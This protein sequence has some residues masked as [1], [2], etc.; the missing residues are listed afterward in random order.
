MKNFYNIKVLLLV[1]LLVVVGLLT[2]CSDDEDDANTG[3]VEL[4]SFGPTGAKHGQTIKIVGR[5]L[6]QVESVQMA[7]AT[8]NKSQFTSQS[9]EM[10]ELVIPASAER[11]RITLKTV[12]GQDIV[13]K[14]VLSFEVLVEISSVTESAK[15]G[16]NI[17]V[18]GNNLNWVDSVRFGSLPT[19]VKTFVSKSMTELVL[20]VPLEAKTGTM[21]FYTG[22]TEPLVIETEE[23]LTLTVPSISGFSPNPVERGSNLTIT[24]T[25]LDLVKGVMF[26]GVSEPVTSFVSRSET[27][28]VVTVPKEANK[29]TVSIISYSGIEDI[30]SATMEIVGDLPPLA[31]LPYVLYDDARGSGWGDWGWGGPSVWNSTEKVREGTVA[32]KK[33]YDGSNDAIRVHSDTPLSMAGYTKITFSVFGGAGTN[34]KIM[35]LVINEQWSS[36]YQFPIVEGEWT[37]YTLDLSEIGSPATISDVLFQSAAWAGVVH[38]DHIGFR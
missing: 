13:S 30:S 31:A 26:K 21:I 2:S 11:G 34:G 38:Y 12:D 5:N 6:T 10:I 1:C 25:N 28:L 32:A 16:A 7:G 15:P 36:P 37:T 27:Q 4:L 8:V 24:G 35:K 9:S 23:E 3:Q 18:K 29:G 19:T 33:T 20:T 22:G 14:T 17:T